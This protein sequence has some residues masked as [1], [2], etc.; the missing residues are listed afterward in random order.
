MGSPTSPA[1]ARRYLDLGADYVLRS[2]G[3]L[4]EVFDGD[5]VRGAVFLAAVQAS[6]QHLRNDPGRLDGAPISDASRRPVSL[7]AIARSLGLSI[8]TTRRHV[9]RLDRDG[10]LARTPSGG[11]VVSSAHLDRPDLREA[12]KTNRNNI[13]SV[14]QR[15]SRDHQG[16]ASAVE[17]T[18]DQ[19]AGVNN[20]PT[21]A[22]PARL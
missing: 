4:S 7:S 14:A 1:R 21:P 18:G 13:A 3:L 10:F 19:G 15:L 8:E 9:M 6:T 17:P 5:L 11:V 22:P 2:L 16:H 12:V 20:A